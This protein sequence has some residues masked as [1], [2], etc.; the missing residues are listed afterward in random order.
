MNKKVI[1]FLLMNF[2]FVNF[3]QYYNNLS[4]TDKNNIVNYL[5]YYPDEFKVI[6]YI[7]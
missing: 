1:F 7:I 6:N 3:T 5:I 2:I 4:E